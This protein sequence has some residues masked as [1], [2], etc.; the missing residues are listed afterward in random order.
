MVVNYAV[1]VFQQPT[2]ANATVRCD[3]GSG[4][5]KVVSADITNVD[6][7]CTTNFA[8]SFVSGTTAIMPENQRNT[9]Y[10]PAAIDA[11]EN[12]PITYSIEPIGAAD[13]AVFELDGTTGELLFKA[14][15][16]PDFK[17]AADADKLNTYEVMITASDGLNKAFQSLSVTVTDVP[18]ELSVSSGGVK[19]LTFSWNTYSGAT[20]Y[21]LLVNPD[22]NSGYIQVGSDITA[23]ST[24]VV[25]PV[26]LTDWVDAQYMLEAYNGAT[27]LVTSPPIGILDVMIN[28]IGYFK[29]SNT[30]AGDVFGYSVSLSADGHTLAVGAHL[31]DSAATGVNDTVLGQGDNSAS[32][33]GAVFVYTRN[34][35]TGLWSAIDYIKAPNTESL[36]NF[37]TSVS[38]SAD[39]NTLAVGANLE[40]SGAKGV[41]DTILGQSDNS[42]FGAGAVYVYTRDPTTVVW[43]TTIDYIKA[44]NTGALDYFGISV[45]LSADGDALAVGASRESSAAMG[46][47]DTIIGQDDN[48]T[49]GAGAVYV[50]TRNPATGAWNTTIDYIKASNTEADDSFGISI[51][52]SGNTLAVGASWE[53]SAAT[54]VNNTIVGQG[55]NS[56]PAAGAVYVY[57]RDTNTGIWTTIDYI[58][59]S[60]TDAADYFGASLSLSSNGNILAVG[61]DQEASAATSVNNTVV[62][63]DNNSANAAGAVYIYTRDGATGVW[64]TTIDYIKAS[65]IG[66]GR[67]FGHS[68][69]LSADAN[70]LAVGA[71]GEDSAARGVNDTVVG[72]SDLSAR[73]AGAVYV[74]TR[75]VMTGVWNTTIDYIKASN[76]ETQEQFGKSVSL[77]ADA[78]T[79]A[80]GAGME[81]SSARG[82]ND[83]VVDQNDNSALDAGAVYVY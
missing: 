5:G 21:K 50:Y 20:G 78:N 25:I 68:V 34:V 44:P 40:D 76:T 4:T 14:T 3:V 51:N 69:N 46:V 81:D 74:Y 12:D 63:Q 49:F 39:G 60:N 36:D 45:S 15:S 16:I 61:A 67:W 56:A 24:D 17:S 53:G 82:V 70:A 79:L 54:G 27:L 13:Q 29:A 33:A 37:G 72:Q 66:A 30:E 59:A 41:N 1:T 9:G 42:A 71:W 83:T 43:N 65:N 62:G 26:H 10:F 8:P 18:L 28:S 57:T 64:S 23:T 32:D 58:K 22:G 47:N 48:S 55:D 75:D 11:V 77:S 19:T 7:T 38:L 52:L 73:T 35:T 31:E 6:I 2:L 80:V